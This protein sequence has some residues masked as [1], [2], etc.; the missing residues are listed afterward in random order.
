MS[1]E[2]K[3]HASDSSLTQVPE[4]DEELTKVQY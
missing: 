3:S 1:T 4:I 2:K